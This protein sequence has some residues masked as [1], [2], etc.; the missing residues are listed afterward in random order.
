MNCV[1]LVAVVLQS[2]VTAGVFSSYV[3]LCIRQDCNST[4]ML[5]L[6]ASGQ[7]KYG[8]SVLAAFIHRTVT[9]IYVALSQ[10]M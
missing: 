2:T 7:H 4:H 1:F 3:G 6:L 9:T 8:V 10:N 5:C